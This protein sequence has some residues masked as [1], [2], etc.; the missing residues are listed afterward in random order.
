MSMRAFSEFR[1]VSVPV[2]RTVIEDTDFILIQNKLF[3]HTH[4]FS[5]LERNTLAII[6][7]LVLDC[8]C[9]IG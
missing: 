6:H 5:N 8:T 1:E 4:T 2:R 7:R 3:T 9:D